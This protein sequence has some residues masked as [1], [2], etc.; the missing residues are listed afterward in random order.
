MI[1]SAKESDVPQ[2]ISLDNC[3]MVNEVELFKTQLSLKDL[4]TEF[5]KMDQVEIPVTH[6]FSGGVYIREISVPKGTIIIGKRH[7]HESCN[8][9]MKGVLTLYMGENEPTVTI[10]GPLL[11]T[12]PPGT[13]KMAYCHEDVVFLNIHPTNETDLEKIEKEFIIPE[14]E[15]L[16]QESTKILEL[17]EK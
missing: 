1:R 6:T 14:E 15:Y 9:L 3:A 17:E 5:L 7:R 4:E 2:M 16:L 10:E 8:V 12:S 11:F 13:K